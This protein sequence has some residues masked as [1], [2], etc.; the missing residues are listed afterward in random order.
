MAGNVPYFH[1]RDG[2]IW[3]DG[4]MVDWRAANIHVLTHGLHYGSAVFEGLRAYDGKIFKLKEHT[5]RLFKSADILDMEIPFTMDEINAACEAAIKE[6]KITNG[7]LRPVVWRGSEQMGIAAPGARIRAAVAA[8]EWPS[9]FDARDTGIVLKTG[10]WKRPPPECAP[11]QAKAAGLY[12]IGTLSKHMVDKQ[13]ANEALMLDWRGQVTEATSSNIFLM[14]DGEVHTPIP[15]CFLNGITRQ[16]V[17]KLAKDAGLKV[18]ERAIWPDEL[19]KADE[20]F[21]TGTA[22]EVT[23]VRQIDDNHYTVGP[24]TKKLRDAYEALVRA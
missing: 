21:L 4:Q 20:V 7:Y 19:A 18:I 2:V 9:Y 1:D 15:D 5:E 24:I 17:I 14:Y 22:V 16:T 3:M 13:G 12:M 10:P 6:N 8:W 23:P 11:C